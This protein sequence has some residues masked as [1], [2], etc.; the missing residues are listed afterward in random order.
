VKYLFLILFTLKAHALTGT[1][2]TD[3]IS[4]DLDNYYNVRIEE[5]FL[6]DDKAQIIFKK[7]W[8]LYV[9]QEIK[10]K[11][12]R[13][14]SCSFVIT[15]LRVERGA[16]DI[17]SCPHKKDIKKGQ[18]L[19][20]PPLAYTVDKTYRPD[21]IAEK[22]KLAI[23]DYPSQNE[24]WYLYSGLGVSGTGFDPTI[25]EAFNAFTGEDTSSFGFYMDPLG[26]YWPIN[27]HRSMIGLLSTVIFDRY[28]NESYFD[29]TDTTTVKQIGELAFWQFSLS[30]SFFHFF[31]ENIGSGWFLRGEIGI[32]NFWGN[33]IVTYQANDSDLQGLDQTYSYNPGLDG[34]IGGGYAWPVS[35]YTR[36]M[37]NLNYQ[38]K[39]ALDKD[40]GSIY[41]NNIVAAT[42]G[43]LF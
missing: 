28:Q 4:E 31:G 3:S 11:F 37:V 40:D 29:E 35:L 2:K 34:L 15:S 22:E 33:L 39:S 18:L 6:S 19:S 14:R 36:L 30:A 20:I 5:I 16:I 21:S 42:I 38:Y 9:G 12:S 41:A 25:D 27:K 7:G 1:L 17:S 26:F 23:G 24:S 8:Q 10:T 43:F 13:N 32:S